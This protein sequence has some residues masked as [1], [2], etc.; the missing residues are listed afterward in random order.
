VPEVFLQDRD[1][2]ERF[3]REAKAIAALNHPNIVTIH[4]I[5]EAAGRRFLIMEKVE[6]KSL[7]R[8][9]P[10]NGF[11]LEDFL[12]L[13]IPMADALDLAPFQ[14]ALEC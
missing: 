1:R 10:P 13:A 2:L 12:D 11:A 9:L 6:G 5:E 7:D 14:E 3:E 4:G 8:K